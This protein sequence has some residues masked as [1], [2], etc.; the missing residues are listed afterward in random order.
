MR[1]RLCPVLLCLAALAGS[2]LMAQN[3]L[4]L[5]PVPAHLEIGTGQLVVD[6]G[7]QVGISGYTDARLEAAVERTLVRLER[8][9]GVGITRAKPKGPPDLA[10]E[11]QGPGQKVQTPEEDESYTLT[12]TPQGAVLKAPTVVGALR[13]LET[14]VQL[15]AQQSS[16]FY[17]PAVSIADAPRFPWRGLLVDV[18]RH[19]Q[20]V[21]VIKR[22]LDGMAAVKLNVLHWHLSE[23]QGFRVESKKFPRLQELGSDGNYYTQEEIVDV[24]AYARARGIR[25]VPEF[26]MPGH[27]T[28]WFVG[29]PEFASAPGPYSI[30]RKFGVFDPTLDPTRD[31]VYRF[32][33]EFI[34]EIS[35]LFPDPYWHIGGDEVTGRQWNSNIRIQKF[36]RTNGL[37]TNDAL[38]AYFNR[39]LEKIL[40]QHGKQMVG[41]DE[42]LQPD[43]PKTALVQSWRGVEYLSQ[44]AR[45]GY[46]G[47]LSAPYYLDH[48][49]SAEDHYL[50]DP[51]PVD[52]PLTTEEAARVLG[53]E[54]CMWGE[55][56]SPE[57]IDSRIWPRV[58]A[59][60]ERLW[61]PASV[62]DVDDMYRRLSIT[63]LEL[64]GLGLTH[65]AHTYRMIRQL[66][67][68]RGVGPL[69]DLLQ[70]VEPVSFG[71]RYRLQGTTQLSPL[72]RL[73]DA[74]RP[75]PWARS[76]LNR[77]ARQ[78]LNDPRGPGAD[79]LRAVFT[80]W[81]E[82][83]AR[84]AVLADVPL[85]RDGDPAVATLSRLG[86]VGIEALDR[87]TATAPANPAWTNSVRSFLDSASGPQGLVRVVGV[88]AVAALAGVQ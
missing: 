61:S 76:R 46:Q 68:A 32:I 28:A 73:P 71:Q 3:S 13:G 8:R 60:A 69:H 79:S 66:T 45:S 72:T 67:G 62:R 36:M 14:I 65:E 87:L 44:A 81:R 83:P 43:L 49:K 16:G 31:E 9:L 24:V 15:L 47:I 40:E 11:V 88:Q 35:P 42:I 7:F 56:I 57:T 78:A 21:E 41:W 4:N 18:C 84:Y 1:R 20:P 52:N 33:E 51:L 25:V 53:G 27:T 6:S 10:V 74:A 37:R 34:G 75:D 64:E 70:Y 23:D 39:R 22:T 26:D 50:A 63:S 12:V 55:H 30:E 80:L 17:L 85:A 19:W 58:V 77:L 59:V 82:L 2:P 48:I 5:M 54:A 86:T 29:Y 38:Q